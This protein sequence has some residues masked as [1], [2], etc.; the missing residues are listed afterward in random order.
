MAAVWSA[1]LIQVG[2]QPPCPSA[3]KLFFVEMVERSLSGIGLMSAYRHEGKRVVS[4]R[5]RRAGLV[6]FQAIEVNGQK[7]TAINDSSRYLVA[8]PSPLPCHGT[9]Q[10]ADCGGV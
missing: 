3:K 4:I 5:V 6:M 2:S 10:N 9:G 1:Y 8:H 7:P